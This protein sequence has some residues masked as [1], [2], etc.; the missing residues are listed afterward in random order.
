MIANFYNYEKYPVIEIS[1]STLSTG[2][3][4]SSYLPSFHPL[5]LKIILTTEKEKPINVT[6]H[7]YMN[8]TTVIPES[9]INSDL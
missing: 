2:H 6:E 1:F 9:W 4:E 5:D 8:V 7:I 3:L